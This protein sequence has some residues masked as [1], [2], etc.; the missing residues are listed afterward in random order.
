MNLTAVPG[1]PL[2]GTA[3]LP[4]DKSI[5]HRAALFAALANGESQVENFLVAGVTQVMLEALSKL[6]IGWRLNGTTLKI[7]G[8]GLE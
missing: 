6:G 3:I 1:L 4:G 5:S 7:P 2:T 8:A